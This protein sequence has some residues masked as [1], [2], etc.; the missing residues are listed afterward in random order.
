MKKC[1]CITGFYDFDL[2]Q[3]KCSDILYID[4]STWQTGAEYSTTPEYTLDIKFPSGETNSYSVTVG[5]PL[6]L[7]LGSCVTPGVYTF[8]VDSCQDTWTKRTSILCL[9]W[10]GYLRAVA[11]RGIDDSITRSIR[12]RLEYIPTLVETDFVAAQELTETVTRDLKKINCGC[13]C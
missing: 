10:C 9:L 5:T 12:E 2:V 13:Q 11:K 4:R 3:D 8:S 7:D 6:H 1:S